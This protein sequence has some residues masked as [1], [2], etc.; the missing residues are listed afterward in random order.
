ME[1][2]KN[3]LQFVHHNEVFATRED[4]L[5]YVKKYNIE[6]ANPRSALFAE[7][8]VFAYGS[9]EK[10]N[11]ILVIGAK[12][13]ERGDIN[14][15]FFIDFAKVEESIAAIDKELGTDTEELKKIKT[16]IDTFLT[17]CGFDKAGR[18]VPNADDELLKTATSLM[19]ADGKLSQKIQ[20]LVEDVERF[21]LKTTDT[22][23]VAFTVEESETTGKTISADVVIPE[24]VAFETLNGLNLKNIIINKGGV[25][26]HVDV[27]YED[28]QL[29]VQIND[30]EITYDIHDEGRYLESGVY[31]KNTEEFIFTYN[32]GEEAFRISAFELI[33]EWNVGNANKGVILH[34][35]KR[36]KNVV[37]D[38]AVQDWQ[39]ILT[40]EIKFSEHAHN[41]ATIAD[42]GGLYVDGTADAVVYD[43]D[44]TVKGAIDDIYLNVNKVLDETAKNT[45]AVAKETERA[46]AAEGALDKK[47][48]DEVARSIAKDSQLESSI[49]ELKA[50]AVASADKTV[51]IEN[52]GGKTDLSVAVDGK[53]ISKDGGK[54]HSGYYLKEVSHDGK[55]DV[56]K[57][58]ALFNV[59]NE[60]V[61]D[62]TIDIYKNTPFGSIEYDAGNQ[63]LILTYANATGGT[64]TVTVPLGAFVTEAEHGE[65]LQVIDNKVSVKIDTLSEAFLTVGTNGIK[66]SGVQNAIDAAQTVVGVGVDNVR[67]DAHLDLI[68]H[69]LEGGNKEYLI[70]TKD[71]A[72]EAAFNAEKERVAANEALAS[73]RLTDVEKFAN[74]TK[75]A[76]DKEISDARAAEKANADAIK[77][78]IDAIEAN[79]DSITTLDGKLADE[80]TRAKAAEE[81]NATAIANEV[82]RA[83]GVEDNMIVAVGLKADGTYDPYTASETFYLTDAHSTVHADVKTLDNALHAVEDKTDAA[84]QVADTATTDLAALTERVASAE[85][86]IVKNKVASSDKTVTV[87]VGDG[88]DLKV[89]IDGKTIQTLHGE[90]EGKLYVPVTDA[91]GFLT[92]T[93]NGLV[94]SGV[95]TAIDAAKSE[96]NTKVD[97][98]KTAL[99]TEVNRAKAAEKDLSDRLIAAKQELTDSI[100]A[101]QTR[102]TE[103]EKTLINGVK[104]NAEAIAILKGSE[105]TDGSVAYTVR[106]AINGLDTT[107]VG[108]NGGGVVVNSIVQTDGLIKASAVVLGS[109]DKSIDF[110]NYDLSV[111]VDNTTIAKTAEGKLTVNTRGLAVTGDKAI[112][113]DLD[114]KI[115]LVINDNDK[116][117]TQSADGLLSNLTLVY[118]SANKKIQLIGKSNEVIS[119]IDTSD[120]VV[121]GMLDSVAFST[122]EGHTNDLKFVFNTASGKES[123]T[124]DFSKYIDVYTQGNGISIVDKVVSIKRSVDSESY[125]TIDETGIKVNGITNAIQTSVNG[126]KS[127]VQ[128]KL[129]A[130]AEKDE[131][132]SLD[133][134]ATEDYV[135]TAISAVNSE[136]D[137]LKTKDA[138][139]EASINATNAAIGLKTDGSAA[140]TVYGV[141]AKANEDLTA[142]VTRA[143]QAE[144]ALT[145]RVDGTNATVTANANEIAQVKTDIQTVDG[146]ADGIANDVKAEVDRAKAKEGEL[147]ASIA[148]NARNIASEITRATEKD[149]ELKDSIDANTLSI[150][151]LTD[152]VNHLV[153]GKTTNTV[154]VL[155]TTVDDKF[156][157]EANVKLAPEDGKN[158]IKTNANGIYANVSLAYD[159]SANKLIFDNGLSTP[160]EFALQGA[161]LVTNAY[162]SDGNIVLEVTTTETTEPKLIEIPVDE[163]IKHQVDN[164]NASVYLEVNESTNALS[165][166]VRIANDAHNLIKTITDTG[167]S[168]QFLF[169]SNKAADIQYEKSV[170]KFESVQTILAN[171]LSSADSSSNELMDVINAEKEARE[172]DVKDINDRLGEGFTATETVSKT[173]KDLERR[174]KTL[175]DA[176][177]ELLNTLGDLA[178]LLAEEKKQDVA[179]LLTDMASSM[180]TLFDDGTYGA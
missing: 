83:K 145:A 126:L 25:F 178:K 67:E 2:N 158:I 108:Q 40:A 41:N 174:V 6:Y 136:V 50:N 168:A 111:N 10:P 141:I 34:R 112:N 68:E 151:N 85:A 152:R 31:D 90:N 24:K 142:E 77:A 55:D 29:K 56:K 63:Q 16:F 138:T 171:I 36:T 118:D 173:I 88:T 102:A 179:T 95:Q 79:A 177:T 7:P 143:K 38:D 17:S 47:I 23:T 163:I 43:G 140:D 70:S 165:A 157:V 93:D 71:V 129:D 147:A 114:K 57:S 91:D 87:T 161:G 137:A 92:S 39:D 116:V 103:V 110:N 11:V 160:V 89:N 52:K 33:N 1:Y 166:N 9:E 150:S 49:N 115:T 104:A 53:T 75:S 100:E 81:A 13:D 30:K 170:G 35:E 96:V 154:T 8:M 167:A 42:D 176:N 123:F 139:L 74:D 4:V 105:T 73:K 107:L 101:E 120:F 133:G 94:L 159:K 69:V 5:N 28:H 12:T 84:K 51:L 122:E 146:K 58:Y 59:A 80:V 144:N 97:A 155:A 172:A 109:S 132:P 117:L 130:K 169:A 61:S 3:R 180:S 156:E 22:D 106:K 125:L 121:D 54:L 45:E 153:V 128:T 60:Q 99:E 65:G 78:N 164:T 37:N 32:D 119:T 162:Y 148:E 98:N 82:T 131:I 113:V 62:V 27:T 86:T 21:N 20:E 19:D 127:E 46:V 134:Y 44:V 14:S 66:L 72:S 15:F 48:D 26:A 149:G 175:E 76:L 18:Y 64:E 124:V 135:D